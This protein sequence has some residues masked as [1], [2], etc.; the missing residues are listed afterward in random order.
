MKKIASE[1]AVT[2]LW[3]RMMTV[4]EMTWMEWLSAIVQDNT[5]DSGAV[6]LS[7]HNIVDGGDDDKQGENQDVASCGEAGKTGC[8]HNW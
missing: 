4:L 6:E 1:M 5:V 3:N 7:E 8:R 2:S